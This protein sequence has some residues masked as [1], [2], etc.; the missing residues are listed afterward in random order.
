M[1]RHANVW[2]AYAIRI[3]HPCNN[4]KQFA[5][6]LVQ[7]FLCWYIRTALSVLLYR[8]DTLGRHVR[9]ILCCYRLDTAAYKFTWRQTPK[10]LHQST[11]WLWHYVTTEAFECFKEPCSIKV[12][13]WGECQVIADPLAILPFEFGEKTSSYHSNHGASFMQ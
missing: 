1:P 9:H 3:A 10:W 8:L 7:H 5:T 6:K 11:V 12:S 4:M 2:D 13:F